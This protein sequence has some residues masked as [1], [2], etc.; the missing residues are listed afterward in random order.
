MRDRLSGVEPAGLTA[1]L[2]LERY[3]I[4]KGVTKEELP[5]YLRAASPIFGAEP[6]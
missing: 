1:E 2:L 3:L 5:V 4:S 6:G